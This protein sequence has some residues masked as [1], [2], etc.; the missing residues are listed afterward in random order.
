[1]IR[2]GASWFD[3][4]AA[5]E[6]A[7]ECGLYSDAVRLWQ[8]LLP[9]NY[10]G[11]DTE[12][13]VRAAYYAREWRTVLDVCKNVRAAGRITRRHLEIEVDV[14]AA[15]REVGRAIELLS[16]WVAVHPKDKLA[17]LHLSTLALYEAKPHLAVFDESRLPSVSELAHPSQGAALIYVLRR[18]PAPERSLEIAYNLYRRFP[19]HAD[20]QRALVGCVIDP[21]A[22]PLTIDRHQQVGDGAAVFVRR[23]AEPPRWIYVESAPDPVASRGEFP[24]NH[25][26]V[27]SMW[28]RTKG[29]SFEYLDH[30]YEILGVENRIVRRVH[31]IMERYEENFPDNPAFRRFSAPSSPPPDAPIE[32]RLGEMYGELKKQES[33]RQLLESM[34]RKNRLPIAAFAAMRGLR[35]FDL[36]RYLVSD[37]TMGVRADDGDPARW[38]QALVVAS[39]CKELVLDGTVLAGALVLDVLAEL[40]KLGVKL[41]VPQAVLDELRELSLEAGSSRSPI[42]TIGL[43]RGKLLFHES[44]PEQIAQEVARIESVI[45]CVHSHCEVVGGEATLDLPTNVKEVLEGLLDGTSIDAVALAVKRSAPLWTD[46]L[47]LQR[48]LQELGLGIPAVWTQAV[49]RAA[50]ERSQISGEIYE[51][52]LGR[53]LERGYAFTR[54]SAAEMIAVLRHAHWRT[55]DGPGEAVIR[56]VCDVAIMNPHNQFITALFIKGV[57]TECPQRDMAKRIIVAILERIGRRRSRPLLARFIYRFRAFH[58]VQLDRQTPLARMAGTGG[59]SAWAHV[60]TYTFDPFGDKE[61]G[62][63]KR[64]LRSWSSRDG[65]CKPSRVAASRSVSE[66]ESL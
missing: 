65:E 37:R 38:T 59:G 27:K 46:D 64:F 10:A 14:L 43:H 26:F 24:T 56:V 36:V 52:V 19:E 31:D 5:A 6:L 53:L 41:V 50:M 11:S 49:L 25:E 45:Q 55:D 62:L 57:W 48:L 1:M 58:P 61:G 22:S 47:G 7:Q 3:L 63:L 32:E 8:V 54:V 21:S 40:P 20:S 35:V 28:G 4:R 9:R 15:S 42:G 29:D 30:Q 51:R 17:C 34:Y 2:E 66:S 23:H 33:H 18:G 39:D 44:S 60:V 13:L 16:E 12:Q